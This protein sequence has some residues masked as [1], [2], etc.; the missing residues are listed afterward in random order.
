MKRF[1]S[2]MAF[3]AL[4][5]LLVSG[6]TMAAW[7]TP[8]NWEHNTSGV[9]RMPWLAGNTLYFVFNYDIYQSSYDGQRWSLPIPVPGPINTAQNEISPVVIKG[10]TV[11]YYLTYDLVTGYDFYRSEWDAAAK[12]WGKSVKMEVWS[13]NGQDWDLWVNEAEDRAYLTTLVGYGESLSLG[14]QDIWTSQFVDGKWTVPVNV[15]PIIN[16]NKAEWSVFVDEAGLI[17]FDSPRTGSVGG[18]D[19]W[20]SDGLTVT[21]LTDV[22]TDKGDRDIAISGNMAV[23]SA[24]SREGGKGS[25]DLWIYTKQ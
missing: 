16:S 25:H 8:V 21:N 13:T 9:E 11:L 23:V 10:G 14:S 5:T 17:Y 20:V 2:V 7:G 15:G 18:I 4:L 19:L 24:D 6:T 1:L 3:C 22:N 12:Q